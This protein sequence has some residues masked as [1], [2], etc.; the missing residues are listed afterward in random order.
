MKYEKLLYKAT[1]KDFKRKFEY[2]MSTGSSIVD[3]NIHLYGIF[4]TNIVKWTYFIS[5]VVQHGNSNYISNDIQSGS[6]KI[7]GQF[8]THSVF[9]IETFG[10]QFK[11]KEEAIKW[12]EDFK[13]KWETGSNDLVSEQR[14]KKL[15]EILK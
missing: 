13:M 3:I 2:G 11:S 6:S 10:L 14:D 15:D 1:P 9:N 4:D 7:S 8:T 12:V 5:S